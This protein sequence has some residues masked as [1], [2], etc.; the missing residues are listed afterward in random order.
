MDA[1]TAD[2]KWLFEHVT[3]LVCISPLLRHLTGLRDC[4]TIYFKYF[5]SG[6]MFCSQRKAC[7]ST[8]AHRATTA[9]ITE[10]QTGRT[11][12]TIVQFILLGISICKSYTDTCRTRDDRL[13]IEHHFEGVLN[14]LFNVEFLWYFAL[15]SSIFSF[16]D[17][18]KDQWKW[19]CLQIG[20]LSAVHTFMLVVSRVK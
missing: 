3:V 7:Y 19:T 11:C 8:R 15:L 13:W 16:S 18:I 4:R 9:F 1:I 12:R 2:D 14:C 5:N 10:N 20:F 17:R 6:I